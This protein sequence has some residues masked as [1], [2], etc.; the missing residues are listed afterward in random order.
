MK[1]WLRLLLASATSRAPRAAIQ[2]RL[3]R[4]VP[5]PLPS[6]PDYWEG[7]GAALRVIVPPTQGDRLSTVLRPVAAHREDI[8]RG[9]EAGSP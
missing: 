4:K 1:I 3:L 2:D 7:G 5:D 9:Y 8:L 6:S